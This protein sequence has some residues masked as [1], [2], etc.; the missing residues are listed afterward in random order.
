MNITSDERER[1]LAVFRDNLQG[2]SL[3]ELSRKSGIN[4]N[5]ATYIAESLYKEGTLDFTHHYKSK[6]FSFRHISAVYRLLDYI[7]SPSVIISEKFQIIKANSQYLETYVKNVSDIT[8][9]IPDILDTSSSVPVRNTLQNVLE[10]GKDG[11]RST[12]FNEGGREICTCI[13]TNLVHD[14]PGLILIIPQDDKNNDAIIKPIPYSGVILQLLSSVPS[15]LQKETLSEAYYELT[16]VIH[17]CFPD[18]LIVTLLVDEPSRTGTIC[19]L[20]PPACTGSKLKADIVSFINKTPCVP[21]SDQIIQS[22]KDERV[23]YHTS[24]GDLF[25]DDKNLEHTADL[26]SSLGRDSSLSGGIRVK[27][28]LI[29]IIGIGIIGN[30][31]SSH[32]SSEELISVSDILSLI[33]TTFQLSEDNRQNTEDYQAHYRQVYALLTKKTEEN[34]GHSVQ[35]GLYRSVLGSVMDH[36][37]IASISTSR[38][39]RIFSVNQTMRQFYSVSDKINSP[40]LNLSDILP[41]D[42]V[43]AFMDCMNNGKSDL[44]GDIQS[45]VTDKEESTQVTWHYVRYR[46]C[47]NNDLYI[48]I[49]E[50][51][52]ARLIN[53]LTTFEPFL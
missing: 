12:I 37:K 25:P 3:S 41:P 6:I 50:K 24:I 34:A 10:I 21:I 8:G 53:Y 26:L 46:E 1:I 22:F 17:T 11:E 52:P 49:G 42:Q 4:R 30:H 29:G 43:R 31:H 23:M 32:I 33:G 45:I 7:P 36:L 38:K 20:H 14:R 5:K 35:A 19:S 51:H 13:K 39:G 48:F 9:T 16:R 27:N 28:N 40:I 47:N 2:V 18:D 44:K 15:I